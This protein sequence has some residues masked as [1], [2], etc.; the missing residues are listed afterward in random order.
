[1]NDR[2]I[3]L[4]ADVHQA[5]LDAG[6]SNLEAM[7]ATF[8]FLAYRLMPVHDNAI[9]DYWTGYL[10]AFVDIKSI[11]FNDAASVSFNTPPEVA[12][13]PLEGVANWF[14]GYE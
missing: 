4:C 9:D 1:M 2:L 12:H 5:Y 13:K 11:L 8:D 3:D 7:S 14:S 10:D 6:Y